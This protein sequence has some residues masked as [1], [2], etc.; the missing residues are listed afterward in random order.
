MHTTRWVVPALLLM[1]VTAL[2]PRPGRAQ[3]A[4]APYP[5]MAPIERYRMTPDAEIAL[6]KS[7]APKSVSDD[8][9]V[10]ILGTKGYETAVKGRSGFVCMV[11]R[12]WAS[13]FRDLGF[14]N[15]KLRGPICFNPAAARSVLPAYLSRTEWA[16]SGLSKSEIEQR[17]RAELAAS[18]IK[19]PE[20]G[21][22]SYMLSKDGYLGDA[23]GG[24]WHPHVMFFVP[25]TP[26]PE[27][28]ADLA[29]SPVFVVDSGD[30]DP[31]V[32]IAVVVTRWSDGTDSLSR[33]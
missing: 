8:A 14:W 23:A 5:T 9:E 17:S 12:A 20:V 21:A 33:H 26:S 32:T 22:M 2:L 29:H 7:A 30:P 25:R 3:T 6:A 16:L 11:Q 1:S 10:L 19:A 18:G 4:A 24:P 27:W 31:F 13:N 28:G 15:P